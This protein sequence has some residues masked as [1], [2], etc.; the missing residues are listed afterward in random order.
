MLIHLSLVNRLA[1]EVVLREWLE[2][3]KKFELANWTE[4]NKAMIVRILCEVLAQIFPK[5]LKE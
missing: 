5:A 4:S 3:M 1:R 2:L